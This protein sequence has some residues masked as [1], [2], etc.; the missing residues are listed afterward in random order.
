MFVSYFYLCFGVVLG[1][2]FI[3][4]FWCCIDVCG[5]IVVFKLHLCFCVVLSLF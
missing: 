4:M 2:E 1:N 5:Y 3:L